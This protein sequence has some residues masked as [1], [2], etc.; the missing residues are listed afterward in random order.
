MRQTNMPIEIDV[1]KKNLRKFVRTVC[2]CLFLIGLI[3]FLR[4]KQ[5]YVIFWTAAFTFLIFSRALPS[6]LSPLF[7][8]WMGIAF[9]LGW[10]NT[11][12]ILTIVYYLAL[13][14]IGLLAKLFKKDLLNL[15]IER[16]MQSYWI[17]KDQLIQS[18]ERYEKTF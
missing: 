14:P 16:D 1:S 4:H 15:N 12:L 17:K 13:T 18:R 8:L 6:I 10:F 3:L 11:R 7:K 9:C 5:G 2:L